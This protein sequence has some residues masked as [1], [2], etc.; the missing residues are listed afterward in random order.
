MVVQTLKSINRRI[1]QP[2]RNP[3]FQTP[4]PDEHSQMGNTANVEEM[5]ADLYDM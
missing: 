2:S 3:D 5:Q 1:S 4:N